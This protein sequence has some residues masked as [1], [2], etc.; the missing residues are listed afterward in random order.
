MGLSTKGKLLGNTLVQTAQRYADL[1]DKP[2]RP[3]LNQVSEM[4]RTKPRFATDG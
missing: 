4:L 1:F 2:L 3:G